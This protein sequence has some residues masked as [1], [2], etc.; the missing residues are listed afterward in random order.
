MQEIINCLM[1]II[2]AEFFRVSYEGAKLVGIQVK[3]KSVGKGY[4]VL[5]H[6]I[7]FPFL[8]LMV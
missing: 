6:G 1:L 5:Y 4:I 3:D 8:W 7:F 2:I